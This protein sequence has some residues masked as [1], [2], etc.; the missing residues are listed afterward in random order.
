M[1]L[2]QRP[3][4]IPAIGLVRDDTRQGN[5]GLRHVVLVNIDLCFN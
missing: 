4:I 2:E 5:D 1:R 3:K